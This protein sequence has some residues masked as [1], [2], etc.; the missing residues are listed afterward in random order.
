MMERLREMRRKRR[1]ELE[2]DITVLARSLDDKGEDVTV[3]QHPADVASD[4]YSREE[5][6]TEQRTLERQ[7]ADIDDALARIAR[8]TYG[9]C[10]VCDQPIAVER[11]EALPEASRC[12]ECQRVADRPRRR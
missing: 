8:G 1:A 4:L 11:L 5:L 9:T 2:S 12:I 3:S 6:V 10:E 7:L